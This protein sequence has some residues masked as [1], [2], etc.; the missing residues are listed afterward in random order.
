MRFSGR[1]KGSQRQATVSE[2]VSAP[3]WSLH[4]CTVCG[5]PRSVQSRIPGW[6]SVSMS[7]DGASIVDSVGFLVVSLTPLA[8][9]LFPPVCLMF[10]CGS[11]HLFSS[12]ARLILFDDNYTKVSACKNR[13]SLAYQWWAPSHGM[14]LKLDQ[15]L[16]GHS[17]SFCSIFI[18]T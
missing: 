12:A 10:G 13:M 15:S 14:G 18:L 1:R 3:T 16:L 11:L 17:L 4:N 9:T 5:R 7:S 6:H 8:P 2:T